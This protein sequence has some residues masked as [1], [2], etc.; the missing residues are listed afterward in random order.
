[1]RLHR[2]M[3]LHR[4]CVEALDNRRTFGERG[5]HVARITRCAVP[6]RWSRPPD[7]G[8][9]CFPGLVL[10]HDK[11]VARLGRNLDAAQGVEARLFG[12]GGNGGDFLAIIPHGERSLPDHGHGP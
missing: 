8:R 10:E 7:L 12:R 6:G 2:V 5:V 11:A 4:R 3:D 1:M 9:I